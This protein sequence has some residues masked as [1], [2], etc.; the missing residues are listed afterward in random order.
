MNQTAIEISRQRW[1]QRPEDGEN[2]A[3]TCRRYNTVNM[4]VK[5]ACTC[6]KIEM[7]RSEMHGV[8]NFKIFLSIWKFR[9]NCCWDGR[10]F[11]RRANLVLKCLHTEDEWMQ[12][13]SAIRF[14]LFAYFPSS[15]WRRGTLPSNGGR[16]VHCSALKVCG[17]TGRGE[18]SFAMF[19]IRW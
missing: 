13:R 14:R 5:L 10:T 19:R 18:S 17:S 1:L 15:K 3:E 2:C 16:V 9:Q 6:W 12:D 11:L 8:D 4:Y 7:Y